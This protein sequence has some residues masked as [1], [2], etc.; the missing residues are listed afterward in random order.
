MVFKKD[1][2]KKEETKT[3][4]E[5]NSEV[6]KTTI[7][8]FLKSAIRG[9]GSAD[10]QAD[11]NLL[12]LIP[13][14]P[15]SKKNDSKAFF[16][17]LRDDCYEVVTEI[18]QDLF[19]SDAITEMSVTLDKVTVQHRGYTVV[20]TFFFYK[21]V[22]YCALNVLTVMTEDE[23]DARGTAQMLVRTLRESLG[24]TRTRLAHLVVHFR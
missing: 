17:Q 3:F 8:A 15:K 22:I 16:F 6:G 14:V 11:I 24:L 20:L 5:I 21:G 2:R 19:Q 9:L 18:I 23:H 13:G 12:H 7:R 10:L 4:D 1:E